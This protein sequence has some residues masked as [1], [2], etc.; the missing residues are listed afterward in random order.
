[1]FM[2]E[3]LVAAGLTAPKYH[4]WGKPTVVEREAVIA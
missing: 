2:T 1:M 3:Q 4:A